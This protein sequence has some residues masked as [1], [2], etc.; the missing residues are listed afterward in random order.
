[1]SE[2]LR[3]RP[4]MTFIT[5]EYTH[6]SAEELAKLHA[7]VGTLGLEVQGYFESG[8]GRTTR[9]ANV[10][11]LSANFNTPTGYTVK[12]KVPVSLCERQEGFIE[13]YGRILLSGA[14]TMQAIHDALDIF[15]NR[16]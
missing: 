12:L 10:E 11:I 8:R 6:V 14:S 3:R 2:E 15:P 7:A 5:I 4:L 1:M 9:A 16:W 13:S